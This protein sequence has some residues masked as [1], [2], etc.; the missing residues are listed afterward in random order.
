MHK[1]TYYVA[2]SLD[3]FIAKPDGS[4]DWLSCVEAEGE[5][6]GYANFFDSID[7]L[8][9]GRATFEQI[10]NFGRWPYGN[11]PCWVWTHHD[12]ESSPSSVVATAESPRAIVAAAQDQGLNHLW[13]VGGGKLAAAFQAER[14]IS[15]Y[16]ISI[17][18]VVLGRGVPLFDGSQSTGR[19]ILKESRPY[20]SGL[21]QL[22]YS[23]SE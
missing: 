11:K 4:V 16:I 17:I 8:L 12:I 13:L 21:V 20:K 6:Y 18:P 22:I 10:M 14:L 7:G 2:T 3:G 15:T 23:R 19:L 1:I 9:M 5:D